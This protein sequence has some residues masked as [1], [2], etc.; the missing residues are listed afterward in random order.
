MRLSQLFLHVRSGLGITRPNTASAIG[1]ALLLALFIG[2]GSGTPKPSAKPKMIPATIPN[3]VAVPAPA[4][5]GPNVAAKPKGANQKS[6]PAKPLP[7]GTD[8]RS[9]FDV[10]ATSVTNEVGVPATNSSDVF[11]VESG[12]RGI[13]STRMTVAA[14]TTNLK[15]Q[16]KQGFKL[17]AGFEVLPEAGF[18]D[19]GLPLR[20]RCTKSSSVLALVPA[21][22][23]RFGTNSGP[24]ESQ[25]EFSAHL[26]T[27]YLEVFEVTV[28]Q[29]ETYR[30]EMK[31]KKKPVPTTLNPTAPPRTP[32]LGVPWGNAQAYAR[33]GGMDLPT[34]LELEK[35]ARG[36]HSFRTPWGDGRAVWP[37]KRTPDTITLA[38]S[39][40]SDMSPYGIYDL[41]GNAKEW[42]NDQYSDQAYREA[43]G[44]SG[45]APHNWGGPKKSLAANQRVVKG[46]GADWSAWSR[47]GREI[48]RGFPDVGFRCILRIASPEPK[49]ST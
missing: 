26:D 1:M 38:G 29:F 34:E 21:G 17:P 4:K 10:S 13:D 45:E 36:P 19:D 22:V 18:S 39:Y 9:V 2:C 6:A 20:I 47:Q 41:A 11:Q 3:P 43:A 49:A 30:H 23:V 46:G 8:P 37:N 16:L 24:S 28:E 14:A 42:C 35:A 44:T 7:P 40:A 31:E 32:V 25:P 15:G 12:S 5:P 48:G 33:W 27:Y